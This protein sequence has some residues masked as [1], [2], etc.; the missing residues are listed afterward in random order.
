[1]SSNA[2]SNPTSDLVDPETERLQRWRLV[3]GKSANQIVDGLDGEYAKLDAVLESLYYGDSQ[4]RDRRGGLGSS[5]PR[6][7]RW[8]GDIRNYFPKSVVQVMQKDAF[9]RLGLGFMLGEPELLESLEVDVNLVATLISLK[10]FIPEKTKSTARSIVRKLVDDV[11]KRVQAKTV[12]AV[13]GA[14]SRATR[15]NKPRLSELDFDRTI[16]LNLRN[17]NP[18]HKKLVVDRLS[19]YGRKRRSLYD[20]VLCVD[21]SGSMA[22]SVVYSSIF[23][24]TLAQLPALSTK[25]VLFDTRVVDMSEKLSDPVD[26]LFGT[27]LGGGTDIGQAL[28]YCRSI[29]TRPDKTIF[30]LITDLYEGGKPEIML[31]TAHEIIRAGTK[32]ICLLA[33]DDDGAPAYEKRYASIFANMGAPTFACTPDLFPDLISAAINGRDVGAWANEK[34]LAPA[35]KKGEDLL[36]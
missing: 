27:Q 21:Q 15:T 20:V 7:A 28:Q 29:I 25:L 16:R 9:D 1:M 35:E 10:Q 19:G 12:S 14:I 32:T 18:D 23:A 30:I 3:L 33:L 34:G 31:S 17:W 5:S 13:T 36:A 11:M 4:N 24:A 22:S 26:L 8:L 6:V 2:T